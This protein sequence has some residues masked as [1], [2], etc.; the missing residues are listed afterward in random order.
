ML[1]AN[2]RPAKAAAR[3]EVG[4]DRAAEPAGAVDEAAEQR[5]EEH[6][7]EEVGEQHRRRGPRRADA[8]VGEQHQRDVAGGGAQAALQ[9]GGEEPARAPLLPPEGLDATHGGSRSDATPG[10]GHL[11]GLRV[12]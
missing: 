7:R 12:Q 1:P 6:R 8:L 9:V 4:D 2:I 11:L 10:H 3:S 5:A